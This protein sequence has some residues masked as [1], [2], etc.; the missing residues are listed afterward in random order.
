MSSRPLET[1]RSPIF[2]PSPLFPHSYIWLFHALHSQIRSM[3]ALFRH[4]ENGSYFFLNGIP[5]LYITGVNI[6]WKYA[7]M[8]S[9]SWCFFETFKNLIITTCSYSSWEQSDGG[10]SFH[11]VCDT[12]PE[13]GC[14]RIR[15][16]LSPR[17]DLRLPDQFWQVTDSLQEKHICD[18]GQAGA[19]CISKNP[20]ILTRGSQVADNSGI[21]RLLVFL[22]NMTSENHR[23]SLCQTG[24]FSA[25]RVHD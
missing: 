16:C 17:N 25:D 21:W 19:T 8:L 1:S 11:T 14:C 20:P 2:Y 9:L 18:K 22:L 3:P 24:R 13:M 12:E 6:C 7:K 23:F 5:V 15:I 4:K 10:I